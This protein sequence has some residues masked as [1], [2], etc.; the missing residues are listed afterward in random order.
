MRTVGRAITYLG[1][2][3]MLG[4]CGRYLYFKSYEFPRIPNEHAGDESL[5]QG[6]SAIHQALTIMLSGAVMVALGRYVY[7]RQSRKTD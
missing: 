1:V 4:G 7:S 6:Y 3:A 2:A 5:W